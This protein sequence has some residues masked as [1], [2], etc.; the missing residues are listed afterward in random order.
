MVTPETSEFLVL[1]QR[2]PVLEFDPDSI[3]L[4]TI[5]LQGWSC[6]WC[7]YLI[8]KGRTFSRWALH[9]LGPATC[10]LQHVTMYVVL[11]LCTAISLGFLS[12]GG[13]GRQNWA[14]SPAC[15]P[16]R[17]APHEAQFSAIHSLSRWSLNTAL[18]QTGL[19]VLGWHSC[20]RN[21]CFSK[22]ATEFG[23]FEGGRFVLRIGV[24]HKGAALLRL[25][26]AFFSSLALL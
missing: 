14:S 11:L 1:H 18:Q 15:V 25:C 17:Q 21:H 26:S 20:K 19:S 6:W 9:S 5:K 12:L 2:I 4:R 8:T 7:L 10:T 16:W 13:S 3:R 23:G 22:A 24:V